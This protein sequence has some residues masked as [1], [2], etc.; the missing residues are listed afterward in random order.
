MPTNRRVWA[1]WNYRRGLSQNIDAP[2]QVTYDMTRLQGLTGSYRYFVSLNPS[3]GQI[4]DKAVIATFD[5]QHPCFNQKSLAGQELRGQ[6]YPS[7]DIQFC[8]AWLGNGF[9][10]DGVQ[11]ALR[12][13]QGLSKRAR[14]IGLAA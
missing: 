6:E 13:V 3:S 1:S 5:Y 11:S 7:S 8:G 10:E 4:D 2:V 9:H 12:V 14:P